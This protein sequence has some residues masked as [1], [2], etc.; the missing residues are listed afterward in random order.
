MFTVPGAVNTPLALAAACLPVWHREAGRPDTDSAAVGRG[1]PELSSYLFGHRASEHRRLEAMSELYDEGTTTALEGL[2]VGPGWSCLEAGAGAGSVAR[3]LA[4]RVA[5]DGRVVAAD[6]TTRYLDE[7]AAEG[8]ITVQQVDLA[9]GP[10]ASAAFDLVHARAVVEWVPDRPRALA[11]LVEAARPGG[12]V[13]VEDVDDLTVGVSN[14]ED[15]VWRR[16]GPAIGELAAALGADLQF[17]RRL[18]A[19]MSAAGLVDVS[20]SVRAVMRRGGDA[21]LDFL[22]LSVAQVREGL[23]QQAVVSEQE[24]ADCLAAFDDPS[25]WFLPPLMFIAWGRRPEH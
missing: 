22:R 9:D 17:G 23:L 6:V 1:A 11:N 10:V 4:E 7:L 21:S 13:V 2:G 5:P 15:P 25:R 3:W 18:P 14:L 16:V 20:C 19:Q 12:L 8:N 24:Y